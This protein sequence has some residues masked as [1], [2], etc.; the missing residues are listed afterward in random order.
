MSVELAQVIG[1]STLASVVLGRVIDAAKA[2]W[3]RSHKE[4]DQ[5]HQ[6][7]LIASAIEDIKKD[8]A[9]RKQAILGELTRMEKAMRDELLEVHRRISDAD[10]SS[11]E[12]RKEM[13]SISKTAEYVSGQLDSF[14]H[15]IDLLKKRSDI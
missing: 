12:M 7:A 6:I 15:I 11:I 8:N 9:S 3:D 14:G 1:I 13:M 4:A 2:L 10:K 5:K